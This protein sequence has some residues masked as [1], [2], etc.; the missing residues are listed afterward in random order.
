M[1]KYSVEKC[2][3]VRAPLLAWRTLRHGCP[4]V[5]TRGIHHREIQLFVS[6]TQFVEQVEG[7]VDH[8][9][10]VGA[11][12]VNFVDHHDRLETQGQSF[13]GHETRLGHGAFLRINEQHHTVHH[14]QCAL[15]FTAKVGVAWGVNDVDVRAFPADGTVF[16]QDGN[17]ALTLN[18]VV[19]HDGVDHFFVF[20]K[21]ARLTK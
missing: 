14:G 10:R 16:G 7:L 3:H 19:V 9:V 13:F 20:G 1:A 15:Y 11:W 8:F 17:A 4:T 5:N 18:G 12:L 2:R 6:S 21:S